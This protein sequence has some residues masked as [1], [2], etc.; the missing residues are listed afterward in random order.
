M[1]MMEMTTENDEM[2][3]SLKDEKFKKLL[4]FLYAGNNVF[5]HNNVVT[6][7]HEPPP[8]FYLPH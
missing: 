2:F 1:K 5:F 8:I 6:H 3:K 4:K 7:N